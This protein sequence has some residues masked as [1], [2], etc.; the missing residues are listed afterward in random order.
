MTKGT[1]QI[2]W[3]ISAE[4]GCTT[5][6]SRYAQYY[7]NYRDEAAMLF[8]I[9][10]KDRPGIGL[11]RRMK[12]RPAHLAYLET[13]GDSVRVGGAMLSDDASQPLGSVIMIEAESLE[14]AKAI[15]AADPYVNADVFETVEIHPFR[16]AA[17]VVKLT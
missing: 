16:A 6:C 1:L 3:K 11:E 5:R 17:G 15:A 4:P 12:A 14:A 7:E 10:C 13:F 2:R 9:I 8:V